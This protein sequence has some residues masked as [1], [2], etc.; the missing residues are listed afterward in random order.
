M[1]ELADFGMLAARVCLSA[2]FLYSG[3]DKS[4]HWRD[5]LAEVSALGLPRPA[6]V[7]TLTIIVQLGAGLMVVLGIHAFA[8]ALVLLAFTGLAT[9]MAHRFWE[10]GGQERRMKLTVG[11]EHLAI[12][13]GLLL[14][15]VSGPGALSLDRLLP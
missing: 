14:V 4:I 1:A 5:G 7:L 9:L 13:G 10:S 3:I 2:V 8:G 15:I 11:L 6:L 12:I